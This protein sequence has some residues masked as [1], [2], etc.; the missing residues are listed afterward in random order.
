MVDAPVRVEDHLAD[1]SHAED[2][3]GGIACL[4]DDV[5]QLL[6]PR[7]AVHTGSGAG[8]LV[9]GPIDLSS[10]DKGTF[11][12]YT[13]RTSSYSAD[14]LM[15]LA[16]LDGGT[17]FP[18][19]LFGGGLPAATSTYELVAV[20]LP[21]ALLGE[22]TVFFQFDARGGTSSGS[23]IR[24]DDVLI[25]APLD[26]SATPAAFGF[27]GSA[28][29]W[30]LVDENF[31]VGI[32]LSWPGPDSIQGFQFDLDWDDSIISLDSIS[33][34]EMQLPPAQWS[35]AASIGSGNVPFPA[36][37]LSLEGLPPGAYGDLLTAH[38]SLAGPQPSS[39]S[40]VTLGLTSLLVA[41]TSPLGTETVPTSG[42]SFPRA[43]VVAQS[44]FD[45]AQ[46]N[47]D[48]FWIGCCWRQRFGRDY[49]LERQRQRLV[50]YFFHR[51][52]FGADLRRDASFCGGRC[53][54]VSG[55][56]V[57]ALFRGLRSPFW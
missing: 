28:A 18:I 3:L 33:S 6:W 19:T 45:I 41:A 47:D 25:E 55:H 8:L 27:G 22:G 44:G 17:T 1:K 49:S 51:R 9:L 10:V 57:Y 13:R 43:D 40:L 24:I 5:G 14:S 34:D 21:P 42:Q 35:I 39:D 37:S 53:F 20:D 7:Y 15:V 29:T 36:L 52:C 32:D 23:N 2:A 46:P 16:S 56:L 54:Y 12:Y 31:Q 26:L 50:G 4:S 48:R 38:F 30:N 11:S